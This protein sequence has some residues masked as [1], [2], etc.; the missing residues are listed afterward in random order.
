MLRTAI[1]RR[2]YGRTDAL[3]PPETLEGDPSGCPENL[4]HANPLRAQEK[5]NLSEARKVWG[6]AIGSTYPLLPWSGVMLAAE[7]CLSRG[8]PS[9]HTSVRVNNPAS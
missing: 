8:G 4:D 7:A 2:R 6:A 5:K 3:K 9:A 1:V